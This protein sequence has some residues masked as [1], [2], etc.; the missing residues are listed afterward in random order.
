MDLEYSA[1]H[2]AFQREVEQFLDAA[3]VKPVKEKAADL[4]AFVRDFR[5]AATER[6][7]LNRGFP[8][9]YGGSQQPPDALRA[10]VI[11]ECFERARAPMEVLGNGVSILAPTLLEA[12]ADWQKK[13]F[14][15]S[16][17]TGEFRWAQ[18][19]SEPGAG[20][21]LGALRSHAELVGGEWVIN[22]HKIW[23]SFAYDCTHMFILVRTEPDAPKHAGISYLLLDL[24]QPGVTIRRIHQISGQSEFCEVFLENVRTPA[25]WIVGERGKGWQVSR[26]TLKHERNSIGGVRTGR[27][28]ES[29][30][31]LAASTELNGRPAIQDPIIRDR[32]IAVE[33]HVQAQM[34]SGYFQLTCEIAGQSAGI[35]PLLN[36]LGATAIGREVAAIAADIIGDRALRMPS[37][38]G[39]GRRNPEQWLNQIFGSLGL[40][41]AGGASNIQRN[42][43]AER[44]LGLPREQV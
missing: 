7:Y 36:K 8:R 18:G 42:L 13:M 24:G 9:I 5:L 11:R 28:L 40:S 38:E 6:G 44:G 10:Q 22:A 1:E 35:H 37:E 2:V 33:G 20:S 39:S 17:L 3:W 26:T 34:Y 31:R 23:T 21:D 12:G 4:P 30:V 14:I 43:I 32:I 15:P 41:I 27:L 29:L 25:D 16:T 19:Y